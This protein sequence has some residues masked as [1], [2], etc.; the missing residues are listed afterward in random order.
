MTVSTIIAQL[1]DRYID[2]HPFLLQILEKCFRNAQFIYRQRDGCWGRMG[3]DPEKES[4]EQYRGKRLLVNGKSSFPPDT[5][6]NTSEEGSSKHLP[7]LTN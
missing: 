4:I 5:N 1:C 2:K 7:K 6:N 3:L